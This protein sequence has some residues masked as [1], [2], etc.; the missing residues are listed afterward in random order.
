[1]FDLKEFIKRN[2]VN[3]IKN[4]TFSK[5][6]GNIMAVNYLAKGLLAEDDIASI[7]S[8]VSAWELAKVEEAVKVIMDTEEVIDE[9]EADNPEVNQEEI[10]EEPEATE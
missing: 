5:E 2:I 4:G 10:T 1:M 9:I 7:E 8:E 6:Y 3:G